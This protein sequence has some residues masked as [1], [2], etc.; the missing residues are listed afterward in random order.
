[1][2]SGSALWPADSS[3]SGSCGMVLWGHLP[4]LSSFQPH[5]HPFSLYLVPTLFLLILR[6][7]PLCV[8]VKDLHLVL[9]FSGILMMTWP[10]NDQRCFEPFG[11]R[12]WPYHRSNRQSTENACPVE[13]DTKTQDSVCR[14]WCVFYQWRRWTYRGPHALGLLT[15]SVIAAVLEWLRFFFILSWVKS[16]KIIWMKT[17][18]RVPW[19]FVQVTNTVYLLQ[20]CF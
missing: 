16:I 1:M 9:F 13:Q 6:P 18:F 5:P 19:W 7:A 12:T 8:P 4:C 10:G 3:S 15:G 17:L 20:W 11:F 14:V 2:C